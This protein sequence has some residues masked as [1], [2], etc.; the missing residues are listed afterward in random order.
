MFRHRQ[1]ALLPF[2]IRAL[3]H[4]DEQI[5]AQIW[6]L[7]HAAYRA[8]AALIGIAELPPLQE[9]IADI[10]QLEETFYGIV[11]DD[12][13]LAAAL[14][15]ES[16]GDELTICRV[17]VH[18]DRFRTG[19]A[20]R[21]LRHIEA[22]HEAVTGFRVSAAVTNEPAVRLYTSLG[23]VPVREYSPL[24]GLV[25]AEFVKNREREDAK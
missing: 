21:L 8:E 3:N 18:P 15:V 14:S 9:T 6:R 7:Q 1:H 24:A 2:M 10:R 22:V 13:E 11:G 20:R 23:Y 4:R 16:A 5:A 12:G 19:L 17:M 25:M